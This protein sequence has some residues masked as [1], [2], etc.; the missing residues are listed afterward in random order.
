MIWWY[1]TFY[2]KCASIEQ[3]NW[4]MEFWIYEHLLII[5][6]QCLILVIALLYKVEQQ[7]CK[8]TI[9][10]IGLNLQWICKSLSIIT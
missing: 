3:N 4:M 7:Q 1:S 9:D 2:K 5:S 6:S 10:N 8:C